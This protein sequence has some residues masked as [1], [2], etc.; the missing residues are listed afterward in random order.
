[1]KVSGTM[2]DLT[3]A[4]ITALVTWVVSQFIAFGWLDVRYQEIALSAG[5]TLL[6]VAW[7]IADAIIR[8]GRAKAL[9]ANPGLTTTSQKV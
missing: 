5:S 8:N 7:K 6:V 1:M 2:P 3:P 9:A 4:Q